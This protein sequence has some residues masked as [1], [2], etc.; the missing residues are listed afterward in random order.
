M[1]K[2]RLQ[3]RGRRKKPFYHIVIA[4]SRSP[5]DG[6]FIEKVGTYNPMTK[7]ATIDLDADQAFDWLLKGAQPTD[8]VRAILRVKGVMYRKHLH[9]G[10]LKGALTEEQAAKM[11]AEW[12]SKKEAKFA[13]RFA[14][15][16]K[17]METLRK[18]VAGVAPEIKEPEPEYVAP[19]ELTPTIESA[20][21]ATEAVVEAPVVEEAPAPA[22]EAAVAE[23]KASNVEMQAAADNAVNAA[24]EAAAEAAPAKEEAP[25]AE[26][27]KLT[28]IEGIGPKIAEVLNNNGIMT[29][30]Q[31]ADKEPAAIKTMLTEAEGNFGAHIPDT[32]P[33]QAKLAADGK[34]DELKELQDKLDGGKP[35]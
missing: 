25:A 34:W 30:A 6:R 31:L 2:I 14:E 15:T 33:T 19:P 13:D 26:P 24:E 7:P 20:A 28:K 27:D 35:A 11:L 22:A 32:W 17:E 5:R 16:A 10:V 18:K 3:R 1:V 9:R 23:A 12:V 8:T 4:D 21:A 29:F